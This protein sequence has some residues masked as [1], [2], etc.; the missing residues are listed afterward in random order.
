MKNNIENIIESKE[1]VADKW[2]VAN[3]IERWEQKEI[4]E[5]ITDL[6]NKD[7]TAEQ[8]RQDFNEW[9]L[10]NIDEAH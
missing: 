10:N 5:I 1:I 8:L 9:V 7:Y 2:T 3:W 6:I 4:Y